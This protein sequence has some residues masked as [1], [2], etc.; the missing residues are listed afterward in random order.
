MGCLLHLV[1]STHGNL[2]Q[3]GSG[4]DKRTQLKPEGLQD[5][6]AFLLGKRQSKRTSIHL[7]VFHICSQVLAQQ[8]VCS[9]YLLSFF[10]YKMGIS[11]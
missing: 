8:V 4:L 6:G 10:N 7:G 11:K 9:L 3:E 5:R 1:E 2:K